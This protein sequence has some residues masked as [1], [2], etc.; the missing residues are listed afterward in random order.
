MM[1]S[2]PVNQLTNEMPWKELLCARLDALL[3]DDTEEELNMESITLT[4][5]PK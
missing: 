1:S 5:F 2:I 4:F 3:L